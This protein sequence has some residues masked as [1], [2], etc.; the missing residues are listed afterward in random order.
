MITRQYAAPSVPASKGWTA[1]VGWPLLVLG[2][3]TTLIGK[4][5]LFKFF[6]PTNEFLIGA[7]QERV[8]RRRALRRNIFW[9]ILIGLSIN[10]I[11]GLILLFV[12][13]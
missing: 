13:Q 7:G 1:V 4:P 5:S 2:L 12:H 11:A 9:T 3:P 8:N 10:V 6:F